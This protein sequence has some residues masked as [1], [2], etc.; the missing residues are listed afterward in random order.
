MANPVVYFEIGGR[1]S[2]GLSEFYSDLFPFQDAQNFLAR[3]KEM[4]SY[5]TQTFGAG[6][7]YEFNIDW[8]PGFKRGQLSLFLDYID[9]Q[10]DDF[11]DVTVDDVAPGEEPLY[12][13]D[14]LVTRAFVSFYY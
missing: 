13:F 7:T 14:S 10:Y 6:I 11:R 4:A 5:Q 1:D 12:S 8:F 3:D 2:E 9:F